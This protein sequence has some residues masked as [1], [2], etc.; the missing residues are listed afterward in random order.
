MTT[1][2]TKGPWNVQ[3]D[4]QIW[5][6]DHP[7]VEK[8]CSGE[9]GDEALDITTGTRFLAHHWGTVATGEAKANARLIAASPRM[10]AL[11]VD[12]EESLTADDSY[13]LLRAACRKLIA[14]VRAEQ[15]SA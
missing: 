13:S 9:W 5:C 8:L 10:F 11:L 7:I 15:V 12:I 14:E 4:G 1:G 3:S 2:F 6:D